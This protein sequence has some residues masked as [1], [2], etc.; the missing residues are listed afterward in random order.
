VG[1]LAVIEGS[2][3]DV[4]DPITFVAN[5]VPPFPDLELP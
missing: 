5:V 2:V 4:L 1:R 3:R